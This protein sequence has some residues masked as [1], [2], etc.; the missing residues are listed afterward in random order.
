MALDL[1]SAQAEKF[2]EQAMEP[3]RGERRA[4]NFETIFPNLEGFKKWSHEDHEV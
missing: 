2:L 4:H 3:R 1:S